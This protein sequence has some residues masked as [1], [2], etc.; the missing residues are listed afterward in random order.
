MSALAAGWPGGRLILGAP[1]ED[2]N[3]FI[4]YGQIWLAETIIRKALPTGRRFW[5]IDNGFYKP[6]RGSI[7]GYYRFM[8]C[9]PHPIF[10]EDAKLRKSR[11][12]AP[13]FKPWRKQG[14]HILLA[15]PGPDLGKAFGM[16]FRGWYEAIHAELLS[17]TDRPIVLRERTSETALDR[18]LQ[19]AW[20]LVTHSS[21]V[22]VDA[23]IAG[24]PVFVMPTSMAAPVGNPIDGDLENPRMPDRT[25]WW[26]SLMCQQ[27][28]IPEMRSGT[29]Y[30]YLR[31]VAEQIEQQNLRWPAPEPKLSQPTR[32]DVPW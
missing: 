11:N 18:D 24:I 31:A 27:F 9:R 15:E 21:N 30:H 29:A 23:V 14:R 25:D 17:R 16:S 10:L 32:E 7:N 6:G 22:A 19:N 26:N 8:Y 5:Q 28:T 12:I 13:P 20:A 3:P 4:T 1:P 2:G